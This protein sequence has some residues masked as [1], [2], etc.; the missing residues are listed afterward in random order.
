MEFEWQDSTINRMFN[1]SCKNWGD[2][3]AL[4]FEDKRYTYRQLQREVL[5]MT[6]ALRQ[7]GVTKGTRVAHLLSDIPEWVE[8]F[9]ATLNLGAILVPLNLTWVGREIEQGLNLTDADILITMETFRGKDFVSILRTQFPELEKA[10]KQDLNLSAVPGLKKL[11]TLSRKGNRFDFAHDFFDLKNTGCEY[12]AEELLTMS[13][14]IQPNEICCYML[15]S[16]STGFPKPVIHTQ[17]S[18]I[19]NVA[20]LGDVHE[21]TKEERILHYAPTYHV[22]GLVMFLLSHLRGATMY[23]VEYFEPESTMETIEKYKINHMWGFDVHYLMMK[24]HSKYPMYDLS[25]M[26]KALMGNNPG[27]YDEIKTMGIPHHG[28]IYGSSEN[29]GC[30]A[31]FPHR[32]RFD[33]HRQKYANGRPHSL[34][35]TK[36]IDPETGKRL[37]PN[38]RGE[39]CSRGP[40]MFQGYYN[41]PEET[42]KAIDKDGFYHSGDYGWVDE[43]GWV[44]YRGRIKDT[45]KSGGENVS[46]REVEINLEAETPWVNTAIVFGVPDPQ[47]GESVTAMVEIKPG[48]NIDEMRLKKRCKEIMAGYKIPKKFIF[49]KPSD[50]IITPTG[51]FDKTALRKKAMEKMGIEEHEA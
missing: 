22:A 18:V 46:S 49:M 40:G 26:K 8:L 35:E 3:D 38:E 31:Q 21:V 13:N 44:Y 29:C 24:R 28:N 30:H 6:E 14:D 9:Y 17:N 37:K 32:D 42:A 11:V 33:L 7:F 5:Q 12:N 20:Y 34:M 15:T 10:D 45:V 48:Q 39:I 41:M 43:K 25:S 2:R 36:I 47:W 50:W 4:V 23:Q 1:Y 16:G 19:F 51:K 27:S